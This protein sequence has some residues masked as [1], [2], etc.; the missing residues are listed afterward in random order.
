MG[1]A[2]F[3]FSLLFKLS[4]VINAILATRIVVQF[5]GQAAGLLALHRRWPARRFPFRMLLYPLPVF[6][7]IL[8]WA[9]VLLSTGTTFVLGGLAVIATGSIVFLVRSSSL[10]EWPFD[11]HGEH[12]P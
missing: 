10:K 5:M 1:G 9:G 2:A 8:V 6:A 4:D 7:A 3:V 12:A 11:R